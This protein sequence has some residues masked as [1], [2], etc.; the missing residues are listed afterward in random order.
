MLSHL[1]THLSK[2][3]LCL[4]CIHPILSDCTVHGLGL[5]N[6]HRQTQARTVLAGT[7]LVR[8]RRTKELLITRLKLVRILA[9]PQ[10]PNTLSKSDSSQNEMFFPSEG[11]ENTHSL[12]LCLSL[13]LPSSLAKY[14]W[15]QQPP[16]SITLILSHTLSH[17]FLPPVLSH[18]SLSPLSS[19]GTAMC[20]SLIEMHFNVVQ[21]S[22][23][24][25]QSKLAT[26]AYVCVHACLRARVIY[27]CA[28]VCEKRIPTVESKGATFLFFSPTHL[29]MPPLS[30]K[31][32]FLVQQQ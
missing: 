18:L 13:S 8:W 1:P 4:A 9:A 11:D 2:T 24:Q 5:K 27:T 30:H 14:S 23:L 15:A 26:C 20:F 21:I 12:S 6:T 3:L 25:L 17:P 16:P 28:C 32:T 31:L 10:P 29:L 7:A 22:S 19:P